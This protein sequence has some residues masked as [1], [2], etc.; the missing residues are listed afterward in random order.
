M[1]LILRGTSTFHSAGSLPYSNTSIDR[2]LGN[3]IRLYNA[4]SWKTISAPNIPVQKD[5]VSCGV[6]TCL[7]AEHIVR[8]TSLSGYN[9]NDDGVIPW[10]QCVPHCCSVQNTLFVKSKAE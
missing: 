1:N 2:Y 4:N 8:D 3:K 9:Y 7:F 5:S 6:Y 10:Q